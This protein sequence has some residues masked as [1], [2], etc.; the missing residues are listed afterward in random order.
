MLVA[1]MLVVST[2]PSHAAA[3]ATPGAMQSLSPSRILD[4]RLAGGTFAS[5]ESRSLQV[6]GKG[7]V[8]SSG[9]SAVVLNVTVTSTTSGGYLTASPTGTA[10][11][12]ASNLNWNA[13]ETIPN[14]VTVKVGTGGQ[15]DLYQS[16]PGTAQVVVDVAGYFVDGA[17]TDPG[18][19]VSVTPARIL[20]T[21]SAGGAFAPMESRDLQITGQGGVPDSNVSAVVVNVTVTGPTASGYLTVYPSGTSRPTASN[22]NWNPGTTI[23]NL[24]TVKVGSNGMVSLFNGS[25]GRVEVVA[26]VAGYY[27]GGTPT[28][29]GMFV[30]VNPA[31]VLDTRSSR[32]VAAHMS[33][34]LSLTG[35]GGIPASGVSAVVLNTTV[36][37]P[38]VAGYLTVYPNAATAPTASNLNWSGPRI[39]IPNLVTVQLGSDGS[40]AFYDG[41]SGTVNVVADTAGYYLSGPQVDNTRVIYDTL[42]QR[43][44]AH[45]GNML[46]TADGTIYLYGTA[47]GC[48]FSLGDTTTTWCGVRVYTTTDLHTFTPTGAMG[49]KYA[50]DPQAPYWQ[51][52]CSPSADH[53]GC[54]RPHVVQRPSDG[55]YVMWI[56]TS[57][58]QGYVTLVSDSPAGLFVPTGVNPVLSVDPIDGLRWGDMDVTIAPDGR[59]YITYTAIDPVDNA[60]TL[61]IEQLDSTLTTGT[62]RYVVTDTSPGVSDL[63]EA[64]GLFYGPNNA[65][66][67]IYSDPAR[68]YMTTGTGVIN[69]PRNTADP[70]GS[71]VQ[72]RTL[73]SDSCMGQPAGVWPIRDSADQTKYVY[74]SDRWDNGNAN[75]SKATNYFGSL[76]FNASIPGGKAIEGYACQS[77][78]TL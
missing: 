7:G 4:S 5:G 59:G 28:K 51:N 33:I 63:A 75:Q 13:G 68:P 11:P 69:G 17:V 31:R 48:G 30:A 64:P 56:N 78:W 16:G 18:G 21:R 53:F 9:V 40:I 49:G 32:P 43:M 39:T 57:G 46:Q 2:A 71:W 26:D 50:F 20:D 25:N 61:V 54:Y 72:P 55:K 22:L 15:V 58:A 70:I 27:L 23:P 10:R 74:A 65:W 42:G 62:G 36:T 76:T 24:V 37:D 67:L 45:D 34:S 52:L 73:N 1:G 66:Y 41:S 38:T 8:P 44:D 77:L 14:A 35:Q 6:T 19:F 3:A 60:H 47:Y 12:L 29:P